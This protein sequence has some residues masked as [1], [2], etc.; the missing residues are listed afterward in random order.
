MIISELLM[1]IEK[2]PGANKKHKVFVYA[3]STCAWCKKTKKFLQDR[4]IEF[5][6]VDVDLCDDKDLDAIRNDLQKRGLGMS[7]PVILVDNKEG[8]VGFREEKLN[9]ALKD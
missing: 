7:F 9:E 3:I 2:V 6:F 1:K 4:G 5:E 8:I